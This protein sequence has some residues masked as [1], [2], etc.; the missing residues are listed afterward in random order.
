MSTAFV[1]CSATV[2][3][4]FV[5]RRGLAV[6]LAFAGMG[7]G[8]LVLP[9]VAHFLVSRVGWRWAYVVF[10]AGVLVFL[11]L[12]ATVMRRDP[13]SVGLRPDGDHAPPRPEGAGARP[14][15]WT[16]G[17]AARTRSFWMI[18]GV[19]AATWV[20]VFGPLVHLVPMARGFGISPL[21]AA[22]LVSALGLAALLGRLLMGGISDR[23]G[24]RPTLAAAL[25]LQVVAF[26]ALS[27]SRSLGALYVAA[28]LFGFSYGG[29]SVMF[30][31]LVAD[32]FGREQTGS[33]VGLLFAIAGSMGA[34]GPLGAGFIYDRFGSY[35]LAWWLSAGFNV[36]ALALLAFTHAPPEPAH[37]RTA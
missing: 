9:P 6:G 34:W 2:A 28:S 7:L 26:V 1:P 12:I 16:I 4:W 21:L 10:G 24:R 23:I 36:L 31:A 32:F 3:R 18:F 22:T 35:G 37:G 20:P 33:L 17:G 27:Q 13:E 11:N 29:V 25:A 30:P 19:F 15:A 14:H 5:R 8:T